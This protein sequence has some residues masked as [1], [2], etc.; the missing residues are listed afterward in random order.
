MRYVPLYMIEDNGRFR[1]KDKKAIYIK[2]NNLST[3]NVQMYSADGKAYVETKAACLCK[4]MT[5]KILILDSFL[6]VEQV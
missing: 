4:T 2:V 3:L 5:G 6:F 1:L